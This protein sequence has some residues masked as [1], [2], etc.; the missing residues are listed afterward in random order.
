MGSP[1]MH[2]RQD[3]QARAELGPLDPWNWVGHP[4]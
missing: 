2:F 1:M 3:A 4:R